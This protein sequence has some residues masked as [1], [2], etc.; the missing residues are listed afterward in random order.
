MWMLVS[1]SDQN[2]LVNADK[3]DERAHDL[4][5]GQWQMLPSDNDLSMFCKEFI[6]ILKFKEFTTILKLKTAD[7]ARKQ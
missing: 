5:R 4:K 1:Q 2:H 3:L 7:Q 6:T